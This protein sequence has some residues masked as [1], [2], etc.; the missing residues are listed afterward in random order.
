MARTKEFTYDQVR[1]ALI[2]AH[3]MRVSAAKLLGCDWGTV[4]NYCQEHPDLM[5]I[6]KHRRQIKAD[7]AEVVIE[8][9]LFH[10]NKFLAQRAAEF[11]LKTIGRD[12][13]Y[14]DHVELGGVVINK[15]EVEI[16][17]KEWGA[18]DSGNESLREESGSDDPDSGE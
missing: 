17:Y 12:R 5:E 16:V 6:V 13:G 14:G 10:E 18:E 8:S 1:D 15:V 9:N 11:I 4:N 2:A 3:G 7:M